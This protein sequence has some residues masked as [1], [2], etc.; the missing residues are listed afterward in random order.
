MRLQVESWRYSPRYMYPMTKMEISE[1]R[2]VEGDIREVHEVIGLDDRRFLILADNR[3]LV[4]RYEEVRAEK[5]HE[6]KLVAED[7]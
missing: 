1:V 2:E 3:L 4:M 5:V 6:T 7:A